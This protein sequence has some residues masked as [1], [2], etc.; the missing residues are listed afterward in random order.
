MEG[1][2]KQYSD[3]SHLTENSQKRGNNYNPNGVMENLDNDDQ[4]P[5]ENVDALIK[6]VRKYKEV[7]DENRKLR[8]LLQQQLENTEKVREETQ[9]T[10]KVLREQFDALL[11]EIGRKDTKSNYQ[12]KSHQKHHEKRNE[13]HPD[14]P[15]SQ[16]NQLSPYSQA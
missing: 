3:H 14:K 9:K 1:L 13:R 16:K 8:K 4:S 5:R 6:K 2:I 10:M 12:E 15:V 11:T 7:K